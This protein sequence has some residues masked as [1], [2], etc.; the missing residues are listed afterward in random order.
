MKKTNL[1]IYFN[2]MKELT[3]CAIQ[4]HEANRSRDY[5]T[6]SAQDWTKEIGYIQGK[7][8][9]IRAMFL[10]LLPELEFDLFDEEIISRLRGMSGGTIGGLA[11]ITLDEY[12]AYCERK[13]NENTFYSVHPIV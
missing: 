3:A 8:T 13:K 12:N 7:E 2:T 5:G 6:L 1:E 10:Y 9:G 4:V 11:D